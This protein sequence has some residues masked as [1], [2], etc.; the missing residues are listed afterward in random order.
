[1][2]IGAAL[3]GGLA[4]ASAAKKAAN[5]QTAAA[6]ADIAFQKETRDLIFDRMDPFYQPGVTAQNALAFELGLG[7]RPMISGTAPTIEEFTTQGPGGMAFGPP[8]VGENGFSLVPTQGPSIT[9]FRVGGQEFDTREAAQNFANQNLSGG[10]PYQGFQATPGFQ[11]QLEQGNNSV[12]ALAGARG[13]LMSG[14]TLQDLASLNQGLANQEYGNYLNRLT[15]MAQ[16]GQSA[17]G[18]Q[19][20]AATN[21]AAG[22]SN[23]YGNIGNAQ[24]AGAI[25]VGNALSGTINNGLSLWQYQRGVGGNS[26]GTGSMGLPRPFG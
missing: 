15:G 14:R 18:A 25:G 7:S 21:A 1:M 2:A 3:V 6:N 17:A 23:A 8:T 11:F 5:A 13:G 24:A 4:Q 20:N 19:A 26:G 9:R 12:N 10:T 22:V 16:G